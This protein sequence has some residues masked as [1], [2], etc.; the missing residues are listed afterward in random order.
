MTRAAS[1]NIGGTIIT[2]AWES[3]DF[4]GQELPN[5]LVLYGVKFDSETGG[6]YISDKAGFTYQKYS[7]LHEILCPLNN[8]K[9]ISLIG[10]ETC[11]QLEEKIISEVVPSKLR[12]RFARQRLIMFN[13]LIELPEFTAEQLIPFIQTRDMLIQLVEKLINN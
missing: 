1:I 8:D 2:V 9:K 11:A 12:A 6:I 3:V 10:I 13:G 5:G 4:S 7:A